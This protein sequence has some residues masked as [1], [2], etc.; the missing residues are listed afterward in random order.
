M[1]RK[2]MT[3]YKHARC[4]GEW[5]QTGI[6]PNNGPNVNYHRIVQLECSECGTSGQIFRGPAE[7]YL[8]DESLGHG[9]EYCDE[10]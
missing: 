4:G 8:N 10:E 3:D 9:V 2:P 5:V 6:A 7:D 1:R